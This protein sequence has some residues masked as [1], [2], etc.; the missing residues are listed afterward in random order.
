MGRL[1]DADAF[2]RSVMCSDAEDMQD[3]IYALRDYP[4]AY[5]PDKVVEQ[6]YG[7]KKYGNKYDSYWDSSLYQMTEFENKT[8][9]DAVE[10]AIEIVKGGGVDA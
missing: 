10:K 8:I 4:T 2:E 7:L 9:N 1:I 5:D 3:V 6:L